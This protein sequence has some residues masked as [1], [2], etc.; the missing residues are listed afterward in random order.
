[1][2][3]CAVIFVVFSIGVIK[4]AFSIAEYFDAKKEREKEIARSIRA[5]E[6][7]EDYDESE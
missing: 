6:R 2:L 7:E 3:I 4:L 1:M 5:R